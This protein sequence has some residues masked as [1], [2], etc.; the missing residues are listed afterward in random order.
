[1]CR[2]LM[3][4]AIAKPSR[5]AMTRSSTTVAA[6]VSSSVLRS[7]RV[8]FITRRTPLRLI[9]RTAVI[10]STPPSAAIGMRA[11]TG[12]A[13]IITPSST[14]PWKTTASR[15]RP[16]VRAFTAVRAMAPVAGSPPN[17]PDATLASP[18]PT[19][20]RSGFVLDTSGTMPSATR[21]DSSDSSAAS[22]A[23]AMAGAKSPWIV[24]MS[25]LG[26]LGAGRLVGSAP[27]RATSR[28]ISS[29]MTVATMIAT[30][31]MGTPLRN[32]SPTTCSTTTSA[33]ISRGIT[34]ND[35]SVAAMV[36]HAETSDE[37]P[38]PFGAAKING[39]CCRK[40]M[41]PMPAVNPS[42]TDKGIRSTARP[43]A[44]MPIRI[45]MTP[46]M[47]ASVGTCSMP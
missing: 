30:S 36:F 27:M 4:A 13:N 44:V 31:E 24:R 23:T 16:P 25:R 18:C 46:A 42:T 37:S 6:N 10:T 15:V 5:T 38:S 11:T 35:Q 12:E 26:M 21:A 3:T 22:A 2:K 45:T 47:M 14:S 19:S 17:S 33:M 34:A 40:M 1:M 20:S 9:I 39:N 28:C 43:N 8:A 41:T 32:F 7:A 29:A